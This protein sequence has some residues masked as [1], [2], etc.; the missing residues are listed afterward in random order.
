MEKIY[1]AKVSIRR[2]K[3]L[4]KTSRQRYKEIIHNIN[5]SI[6]QDEGTIIMNVHVPNN[7]ASKTMRQNLTELKGITDNSTVI[8]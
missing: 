4:T 7:T 6:H 1:H 3:C 8:V 2:L 5:G